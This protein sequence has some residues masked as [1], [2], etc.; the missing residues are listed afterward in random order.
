L[1][2]SGSYAVWAAQPGPQFPLTAPPHE[3]PNMDT[4]AAGTPA[5]WW[6][7]RYAGVI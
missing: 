1:I 7:T 5:S 6:N 4:S 3:C 2:A